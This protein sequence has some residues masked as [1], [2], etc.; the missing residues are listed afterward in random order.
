MYAARILPRPTGAGDQ[1]AVIWR[2]MKLVKFRDLMTTGE[3]YFCRADLFPNDV[4]EG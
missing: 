3:L 4:R 1:D 2:F